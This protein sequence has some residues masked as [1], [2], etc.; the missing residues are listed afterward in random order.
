LGHT[1]C[2]FIVLRILFV[3]TLFVWSS[4][5]RVKT[6]ECRDRTAWTGGSLRRRRRRRRGGGGAAGECG[7]AAPSTRAVCGSQAG[8]VAYKSAHTK[9]EA[10]RKVKKPADVGLRAQKR[11]LRRQ[12]SNRY[13][14]TPAR[15]EARSPGRQA[16]RS[17]HPAE[18]SVESAFCS[19]VTTLPLVSVPYRAELHA[20][21][22][23]AGHCLRTRHLAQGRTLPRRPR[24][25]HVLALA[26]PRRTSPHLAA[27]SSHL[28]P[29]A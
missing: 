7:R 2:C 14:T 21:P 24:V 9:T 8:V 20:W 18:H 22:K 1:S 28:A 26:A 16:P 12:L 15:L 23:R 19:R 25:A 11:G 5:G 3:C 13:H 27:S 29:T 6:Q 4:R 17:H 10:S